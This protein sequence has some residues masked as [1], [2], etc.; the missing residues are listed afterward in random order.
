M[1]RLFVVGPMVGSNSGRVTTQ[2][3]RLARLFER[4]GYLVV[5]VSKAPNR[6]IRLFDIIWTLL[7]RG[8]KPDIQ[9]LQVFGGASFVIEDVASFIGRLYGQRI[10]M[11][12][13][14]GNIPGFIGCFPRWTRR[15]LGRAHAIVAPSNYL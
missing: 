3:E 10:V 8:R 12:L 5:S 6:Y 4:D 13:R 7:R 11:V 15:V 2:G 14:G 9:I 1:N